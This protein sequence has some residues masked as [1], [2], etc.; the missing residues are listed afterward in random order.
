MQL[1]TKGLCAPK[2]NAKGKA[3]V[4]ALVA[5]GITRPMPP[6]YMLTW[7]DDVTASSF[8]DIPAYERRPRRQVYSACVELIPGL[9]EGRVPC[10]TARAEKVL[11][12]RKVDATHADVHYA[13]ER[14]PTS[15][16]PAVEAACGAL[17]K[18][19]AD[20]SISLLKTDTS[21]W[22]IAPQAP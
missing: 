9:R 18:P 3:C 8:T 22:T 6:S 5:S 1:A 4:D 10:M 17:I 20:A 19:P 7:P 12:V 16:L 21:G 2:E 13:R 15:G 14:T 11:E